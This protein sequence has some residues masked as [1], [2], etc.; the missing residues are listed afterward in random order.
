MLKVNLTMTMTNNGL[1]GFLMSRLQ[2]N[3]FYECGTSLK[4]KFKCLDAHLCSKKAS[5]RKKNENQ[6][7]HRK[8]RRST[9]FPEQNEL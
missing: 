3:S 2:Q 5:E 8:I 6:A 4:L 7:A 1:N 9:L